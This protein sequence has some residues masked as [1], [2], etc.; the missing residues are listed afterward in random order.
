MKKKEKV[1]LGV[2]ALLLIVTII[3]VSYAAF[4]FAQSGKNL[5]TMTTGI[6]QMSYEESSNIIKMTGALPTTD[7]TGKVRLNEGEYFDF[8]V[9]ST[10]Q[11][12]AQ[13]N[14]EIAAEDFSSNTFDGSHVKLYL[15]SLDSSGNETQVMSPKVFT[16]VTSENKKTGRPA[17]M[18]SLA[19]GTMSSSTSTK[20]RLRMWVSENYNPQGDG[21]NK[22]FAVRI[23]VY[24]K[25]YEESTGSQMK[26]VIFNNS[27]SLTYET[28]DSNLR[29]VVSVNDEAIYGQYVASAEPSKFTIYVNDI[30]KII[31]QD[32]L[33]IPNDVTYS[34]DVSEASDGSV[35]VYVTSDNTLIIAGQDGVIA[36]RYIRFNKFS[37]V[38]SLDLSNLDTSKVTD[39]MDMFTGCSGLTSLDLSNF[40]TSNVTSS[41]GMSYMF[42]NCSSLTNLDLSNFDT[43]NVTTFINMF[44]G[45]SSLTSLDLSNFNTSKVINMSSMFSG[46]SNLTSLDLSNFNTSKVLNMSSMFANCSKMQSIKV[47]SKWVVNSGCNTSSMFSNCGVSSVTVV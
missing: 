6:M 10:I 11:G 17:N 24:G 9:S 16:K 43:S 44:E 15:T 40:D 23:N 7:V 41:T 26:A 20:Y 42:K 29:N 3:G 46:C 47:S 31:I 38:T 39:M 19:T 35:M 32:T 2:I 30:K 27:D 28:N 18:M 12:D 36:G 45:C 25:L 13:I 14:W 1:T 33:T 37:Q 5:N 8:T 34:E 22:K 21:G 4:T